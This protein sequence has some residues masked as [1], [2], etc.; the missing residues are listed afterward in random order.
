MSIHTDVNDLFTP[1]RAHLLTFLMQTT[2]IAAMMR[3][4][5]CN[6]GNGRVPWIGGAADK[7]L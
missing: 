2:E 7:A 4:D 3:A 1:V 6:Q 5:S